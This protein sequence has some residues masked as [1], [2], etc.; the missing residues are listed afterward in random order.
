MRIVFISVIEFSLCAL[1]HLQSMNAKIVGVCTL[2]YSKFNSYYSDYGAVTEENRIPLFY[3][4][5]INSTG[6]LSWIHDKSL[7]VIFSY[8]GSSLFKQA[9]KQLRK[10]S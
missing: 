10:R 9:S 2:Q 1:K 8:G 5:D 7:D 4:K 3:I 6:T